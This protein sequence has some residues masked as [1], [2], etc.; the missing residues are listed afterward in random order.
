[1]KAEPT[2][3]QKQAAREFAADHSYI[4][5]DGRSPINATMTEA[6]KGQ[7]MFQE[8]LRKSENPNRLYEALLAGL[9]DDQNKNVAHVQEE[10]MP[11]QGDTFLDVTKG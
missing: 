2:E 3:A 10:V 11:V 6:E 1:M 7:E 4:P 8:L 9:E 5:G